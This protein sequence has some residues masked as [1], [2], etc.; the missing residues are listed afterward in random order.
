MN[1]LGGR[2]TNQP[3]A[4][5]GEGGACVYARTALLLAATNLITVAPLADYA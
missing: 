3:V 4:P 1:E 2:N 5:G